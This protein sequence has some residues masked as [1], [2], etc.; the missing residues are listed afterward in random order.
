M[1]EHDNEFDEIPFDLVNEVPD[2]VS[3]RS[4]E[5]AQRAGYGTSNTV[6][7]QDMI[8]TFTPWLY[9]LDSLYLTFVG[10]MKEGIES[11]LKSLQEKAQSK[12]R[13]HEAQ[14][15][16]G[17]HIFEVKPKGRNFYKYVLIGGSYEIEI[18][19]PSNAPIC[20]VKVLSPRLHTASL[21]TVEA[22]LFL[23]L[24]TIAV[25]LETAV[26]VRADLHLD[27][28]YQIESITSLN[29]KCFVSLAK[30]KTEYSESD[31]TTGWV[32]GGGGSTMAR[33]YNKTRQIEA[34]DKGALSTE[35]VQKLWQQY[36]WDGAEDVWRMEY[37]VRKDAL[38]KRGIHNVAQL[39]ENHLRLWS[40]LTSEWLKICIPSETDQKRSRWPE[41]PLWSA[42][43]QAPMVTGYVQPLERQDL[44]HKA[45]SKA[46]LAER[47]VLAAASYGVVC[48]AGN[49]VQ[50]TTHAF[51]LLRNLDMRYGPKERQLDVVMKRTINLR[52]RDYNLRMN[53]DVWKAKHSPSPVG[54]YIEE[55]PF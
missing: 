10:G 1:S 29:R 8:D 19:G 17:D 13:K 51:D 26:P 11:Q 4:A 33:L 28:S 38:Q 24:D 27:F 35:I 30:K 47:L 6:P 25:N 15:Q 39:E 37:Q 46:Y 3:A 23:L 41:H 9:S 50:V 5:R 52:Y 53:A 2:S 14:Y 16:M 20:H 31:N 45:P 21:S 36:G 43:H 44:H 34:C 42:I 54:E 22:E 18:L 55:I 48:G 7:N 49:I 32:I 12:E 40:Y